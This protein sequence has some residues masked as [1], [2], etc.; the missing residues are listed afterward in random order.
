MYSAFIFFGGLAD[1]FLSVMMWFILDSKFSPKVFIDG[2]RTYSVT[3][4]INTE[5]TLDYEDCV[6]E[7]LSVDD[8]AE[9]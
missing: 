5:Q 2:G 6:E 7:Q 4:V 9:K 8:V 1:I 3:D